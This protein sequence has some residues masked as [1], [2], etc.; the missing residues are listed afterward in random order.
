MPFLLKSCLALLLGLAAMNASAEPFTA[1]GDG[2]R[3]VYKV[4][5]GVIGAGKIVISAKAE[6]G[7]NGKPLMR[8]TNKIASSG[9]VRG[10]Y[11][12]D[13]VAEILIER[14]TGRML[15]SAEKGQER[16]KQTESRTDFDYTTN[17][18]HHKDT[19]RPGRN[20]DIPLATGAEPMDLIS[21]LIQTRRWEIK[22]G[23]SRDVLVHFGPDLFPV[24]I[25]A[26]G[27]EEVD[28]PIGD[29]QTML[30]SPRME[31]EPPR[32]LFKR[33]GKIS[34][35][36]AQ[37]GER[38]PVKMQLQLGFGSATLKLIEHT[39]PQPTAPTPTPAPDPASADP[40]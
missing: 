3:L 27:I 20:R 6:T 25:H 13:N 4:S 16:N 5:W 18:A 14:D 15:W 22:V 26:E 7:P 39:L 8:I 31:K 34:V 37:S 40:K 2:E 11:R 29:F 38:L 36:V 10:L 9:M 17:L 33:G 24:T 30:L 32:G 21:A 19:Y 35:W 23:E 1:F 12:F 28:T